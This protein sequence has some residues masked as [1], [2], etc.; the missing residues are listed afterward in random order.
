MKKC[1][2]CVEEIQDEA[3]KCKHC[4]EQICNSEQK[5]NVGKIKKFNFLKAFS[6]WTVVLSIVL[7]ILFSAISSGDEIVSNIFVSI[8]LAAFISVIA[9]YIH[10]WIFEK[11][12]PITKVLE[13][14]KDDSYSK[15]KNGEKITARGITFFG[16][17]MIFIVIVSGEGFHPLNI[18]WVSR[19]L[20]SSVI[21]FAIAEIIHKLFQ[22]KNDKPFES[23]A[24]NLFWVSIVI[25]IGSIAQKYFN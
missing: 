25:L 1:P 8:I 20:I 4:G 21:F 17:A 11:N 24:V 14:K 10:K 13:D 7:I 9:A 19:I 2:Y 18:E 23:F 16:L 6:W 15:Q 5:L 3:I 22:K 12:N